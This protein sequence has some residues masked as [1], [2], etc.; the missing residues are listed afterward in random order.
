L[1]A[2]A[3]AGRG[4]VAL[5]L[6]EPGIGKSRLLREFGVLARDGVDAD[7][8]VGRCL[9]H[10]LNLPYH[11]ITSLV[12]SLVG[13]GDGHDQEEALRTL[14]HRTR[15]LLGGDHPAFG[16]LAELLGAGSGRAEPDAGRGQAYLDA[17]AALVSAT[18]ARH[19]PLVLVAEDIHWAD[20]SSSKQLEGLLP[21]CHDAPV[22]FILT[23]RPDRT[24]PGWGV[25]QAA[26]GFLGDALTEIT[27]EPLDDSASR[28]LVS[29]LLEIE[30]LPEGLRAKVLDKAEG[31][32]FFVEEVVRMLIERGVIE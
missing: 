6:G 3:E 5:I 10:G 7:W 20:P 15:E 25:V 9:S 22:L 12:R 26:R 18:A 32:P 31:N 27:L 24:V 30:A 4:R 8:A 13:V 17:V 19:S 14:E 11:L 2:A 23:S 16:Y 28:M 29:N 21:I 1:L